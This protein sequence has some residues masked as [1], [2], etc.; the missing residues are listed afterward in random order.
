MLTLPEPEVD[1]VAC[2]RDVVLLQR[3]EALRER[4]M[5]RARAQAT[6]GVEGVVFDDGATLL[7]RGEVNSNT[8]PNLDAVLDGIISLRPL[9]LT[10]DL[11]ETTSVSLDALASITRRSPEVERF[12]IRLPDAPGSTR[13]N[14]LSCSSEMDAN[15]GP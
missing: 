13:V 11:T 1:H 2:L 9:S 3:F 10:I 8:T 5:G 4:V 15:D 14:L 12:A 6:F 7:L